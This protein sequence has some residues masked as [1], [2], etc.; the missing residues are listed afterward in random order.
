MDEDYVLQEEEEEEAEEEEED[1]DDEGYQREF[2][3]KQKYNFISES[4]LCRN[5]HIPESPFMENQ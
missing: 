1:D 3:A 2:K 5:S 4:K